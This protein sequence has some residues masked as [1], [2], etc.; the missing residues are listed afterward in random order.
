MFPKLPIALAL[1]LL[2]LSGCTTHPQPA[3]LYPEIPELLMKPPRE[4]RS[5]PSPQP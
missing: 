3:C 4:L 5:L 2:A 1:C